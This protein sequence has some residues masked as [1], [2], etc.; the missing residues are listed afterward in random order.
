MIK[1]FVHIGD[2]RTP[3]Y[4]GLVSDLPPGILV[5]TAFIDKHIRSINPG[6]RLIY[7]RCSRPV[8]IIAQS[9]A[10]VSP[11]QEPKPLERF[12]DISD[13][14]PI[15]VAQQTVIPAYSHRMVV[16]RCRTSG[17]VSMIANNKLFENRRCQM[18]N[19]I[20]E[21]SGEKP[22]RVYVAN[23]SARPQH[24]PKHMMIGVA[25]AAPEQLFYQPTR[26]PLV[27]RHDFPN[28]DTALSVTMNQ[29]HRKDPDNRKEPTESSEKE[30][31]ETNWKDT[32]DIGEESTEYKTRLIEVLEKHS[33]M[34]DGHLGLIHAT[35]HRIELTAEAKPV[36]QQPYRAGPTQREHEKKE[37]EKMLKAGVI[38]PSTSEWAAPVVF[39]P[40]KDG[41]L[42]FCVDY[43]RLNA[44]TLRDS[45]P[46]P[47]MDECIDSLGDA[48]IFST[49]DF[50]SGYW[51]VT[52]DESDK[53]KTAFVTHQGLFQF[54]RM[55]FGLR[56][57]PAT[58]QRAIDIILSS[59]K[60]QYCIV[61][62]DD[63]IIFSK[64]IGDHFDHLNEVL[65]LLGDAGLSIRLNKSFFLHKEIEY[66]GH[67]IAPGQL[68]VAT[69]TI[70]AIQGAKPPKSKT[71]IKSFVGMCNVYRRFIKDFATISAPLNSLLKKDAPD[72]FELRQ[73]Q[74]AAFDT[75][76]EKLANPPILALPKPGLPYVLDTDA[77]DIQV[78]CVLQQ[79][80][81]DDSLHPIGYFSR[82]L[83]ETERKYDTTEKECLGI[84][85]AVLL[86]RPYLEM[87]RFT[88]RTDHEALKWLFDDN[89]KGAKLDRWRLRLQQFEFDVAHL[90]GKQ[91]Q[92]ADALS[93]LETTT[94]DQ[95]K[96]FIDVEIPVFFAEYAAAP[97]VDNA[98]VLTFEEDL[99]P[100]T[101]DIREMGMNRNNEEPTDPPNPEPISI[102]EF[103]A[104]QRKDK[105]CRYLAI[106][107]GTPKA[108]FNFNSQGLLVRTSRI[109]GAIQKVVPASLREG[110]INLSHSPISQ[111]HPGESRLD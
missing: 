47:R 80:H 55:P 33:R 26:E 34:W 75:L 72:Q 54:T 98:H 40:K 20:A 57:A 32:I 6:Q 91:N 94:G 29:Q 3:F 67:V 85:W 27:N 104:E 44:V 110:I 49:L 53:E 106:F 71:E 25:T 23:F 9:S 41:T 8:P 74:I 56:N 89:S 103:A 100:D 4:F 66:L 58:F 63:V 1:L 17:L 69:K 19:G 61:Y 5:G 12:G 31:A 101:E 24:L 51:Q 11:I 46:I 60:W 97:I 21:I 30:Q 108:E 43:R 39:A 107:A 102:D 59:V 15:R 38:E 16:V 28:D 45:Y 90:P 48:Q 83:N 88:L 52:I 76:R 22:F 35:K 99:N 36:H 14:R 92:V 95:R 2:L 93:R 79:R 109:D 111:G 105:L 96:G 81:L 18:S 77:N 70:T 84:I 65:T 86:L 42:R 68:K 73:E 62:I 7:P 64:S 10:S 87:E 13:E 78:G 37:V 82:T 50:N